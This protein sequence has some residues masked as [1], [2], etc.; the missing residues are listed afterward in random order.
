MTKRLTIKQW[1]DELDDPVPVEYVGRLLD[2]DQARVLREI[3]SGR[4]RVHRFKADDGRTWRVVK[5][6]DLLLYRINPLDK[7]QLMRAAAAVVG[8]WARQAA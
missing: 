1:F 8:R 7:K 5:V 6:S 3:R 4:M 2:M